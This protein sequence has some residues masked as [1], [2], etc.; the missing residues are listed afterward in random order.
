VNDAWRI[1]LFNSERNTIG[2]RVY[3]TCYSGYG[4]V[5]NEG[6]QK[7]LMRHLLCLDR[8]SG[9]VVWQ[10]QFE[11]KLPEHKYQGEGTNG[12][13]SGCSP[14]LYGKLL[15]VNASVESG[16]LVALDKMTGEEVWRAEGVHRY[17]C[18]SVVSQQDVVFAIGGGSTSLAV[19]SGGRGDVTESHGVWRVNKGS[20]VGSPVYHE[21]HLYWASDSGGFICCQNAATGETVYQE[22]LLLPEP[23]ET[24]VFQRHRG[25]FEA[26]WSTNVRLHTPLPRHTTQAGATISAKRKKQWVKVTIA[27]KTT[28]RR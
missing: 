11:P 16:S 7:D 19:R 21:G 28:R 14:M 10:K 24:F 20:N 26:P 3:V 15:I 23:V 22:R 9:E 25:M 17:C 12:W 5:P 1:G 6:D 27:K 8:K 18:P 4:L 13:G 2:D